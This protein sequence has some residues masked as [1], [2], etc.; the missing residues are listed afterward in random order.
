MS[1]LPN[2]EDVSTPDLFQ[3]SSDQATSSWPLE[4]RGYGRTVAERREH[5]EQRSFAKA[6]LIVPSGPI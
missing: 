1:M 4:R 3:P 6:A 2:L 5:G